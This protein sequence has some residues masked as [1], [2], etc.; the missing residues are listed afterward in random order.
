[1]CSSS[2]RVHKR[3]LD[4]EKDG[5]EGIVELLDELDGTT[6]LDLTRVVG[7]HKWA[8]PDLMY[9][10]AEHLEDS[11]RLRLRMNRLQTTVDT[12]AAIASTD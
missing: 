12:L 10:L 5:L 2:N 3:L 1:M 6:E 7:L 8:Q 11:V 4:I 9:R